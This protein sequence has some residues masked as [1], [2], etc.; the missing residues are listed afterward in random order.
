LLAVAVD[1]ALVLVLAKDVLL[2]R[3]LDVIAIQSS[4]VVVVVVLLD[5]VVL[6]P[7]A[8]VAD[9]LAVLVYASKAVAVT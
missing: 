9:H 6:V 8:V 4:H 1:D 7:L 5:S 3:L 2:D